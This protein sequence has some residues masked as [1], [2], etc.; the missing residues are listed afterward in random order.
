MGKKPSRYVLKSKSWIIKNVLSNYFKAYNLNADIYRE[1][2]SKKGVQFQKLKQLS[3][4]LFSAKEDLYLVKSPYLKRLMEKYNA[5]PHEC[6]VVG[7]YI[8]D[9]ASGK[10]FLISSHDHHS[11]YL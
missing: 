9:I 10:S 2:H 1:H 4:I 11:N 6:V 3:G 5:K 7:D 8:T